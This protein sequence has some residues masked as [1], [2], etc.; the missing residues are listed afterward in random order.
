MADI[1][2]TGS[3][4]PDFQLDVDLGGVVFRLRVTY[5]TRDASWYLSI[6]DVDG[7]PLVMGQRMTIKTSILGQ[8]VLAE[9]PAGALLIID[10]QGTGAD[11]GR[12]SLDDEAMALTFVPS[13]ELG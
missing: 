10:P 6:M 4:Q 13:A 11:P 9:L 2:P 7:T 8:Y 5:N 12:L 1:I 3:S